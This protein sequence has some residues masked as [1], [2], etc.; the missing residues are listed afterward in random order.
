MSINL[1]VT[2]DTAL[3]GRAA[4]ILV[5]AAHAVLGTPLVGP[6]PEWKQAIFAMGCFWGAERIFWEL[7]GVKSTAVGYT[8][9]FTKNPRYREVCSGET[10]HTE[11]VL[12]VYDPKQVSY[13]ELLQT[14]WQGHDPTQGMG[15]GNDRGT[16]YR[17][18]AY[19]F[20]EEQEASV[21]VTRARYQE[22]LSAVGHSEITTEIAA[23]SE[24][25]YAEEDH[26]QYLHKNPRGYCGIG[27]TGVSCPIGLPTN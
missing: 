21:A 10:G 2:A 8:A 5:P 4:A 12:V 3:P 7:E 24:F 11:A 9:G 25:Y 16:Q 1:G 18:G 19:T 13:E 27:G 6:F 15:Q 20:D 22:E 26:Q 14:F 23:A 17:S